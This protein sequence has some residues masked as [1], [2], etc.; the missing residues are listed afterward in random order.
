MCRDVEAGG[1][2]EQKVISLVKGRFSLLWEGGG[3]LDSGTQ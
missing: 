2:R 1:K 3:I